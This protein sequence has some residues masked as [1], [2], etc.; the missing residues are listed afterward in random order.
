M[1][2][3]KAVEIRDTDNKRIVRCMPDQQHLYWDVSVKADDQVQMYYQM[4]I[5]TILDLIY[6]AGIMGRQCKLIYKGGDDIELQ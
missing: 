6:R 4:H 1:S 5:S 3:I 2:V